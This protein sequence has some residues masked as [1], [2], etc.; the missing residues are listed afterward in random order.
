MYSK[1]FTYLFYLFL[2][3]ALCCL[4]DVLTSLCRLVIPGLKDLALHR[5]LA[6]SGSSQDPQVGP[7]TSRFLDSLGLDGHLVLAVT[8][9]ACGPLAAADLT[10]HMFLAYKGESRPGPAP[11]TSVSAGHAP[12]TVGPAPLYPS[13]RIGG[14][15]PVVD[16][17]RAGNADAMPLLPMSGQ[18]AGSCPSKPQ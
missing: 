2:L 15:A 17:A 9:D 4:L 1:G 8:A 13:A 16:G 11:A 7:L 5:Y 12:A 6:V 14:T 18:G 3:L 10:N